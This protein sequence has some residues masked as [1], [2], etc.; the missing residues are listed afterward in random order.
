M[1]KTFTHLIISLF[2]LTEMC[3][4]V[5]AQNYRTVYENNTSHFED[6]S[7]WTGLRTIYRTIH[8]DSV[9][10]TFGG[11]ELFNVMSMQDSAQNM[12]YPA[13]RMTWI[14]AKIVQTISGDEIY[15]TSTDDTVY[16]LPQSVLNGSWHMY[17]Y[18]N[19]NYI[20]AKVVDV[21]IQNFIGLND[22][23]KT[24]QLTAKDAGGNP[25]SNLLNGRLLKLSENHGWVQTLGFRYFPVDTTLFTLVGLENEIAGIQNLT[26][27]QIFDFDIGDEFHTDDY[28]QMWAA[29]WLRWREIRKILSKSFSVDSDTVFYSVD[30]CFSYEHQYFSNYTNN[31]GHD[32]IIETYALPVPSDLH[33]F[34]YQMRDTS[35]AGWQ[36]LNNGFLTFYHDASYNGRLKKETHYYMADNLSGCWET[37]LCDPPPPDVQYAE[38]LGWIGESSYC[39]N[40]SLV[41]YRKGLQQW[42]TPLNCS[43][44]LSN[45][46]ISEQYASFSVYPNPVPSNS[47]SNFTFT[48]SPLNHPA[49][50]II[51]NIDGREVMRY[52]VLPGSVS[53]KIKLPEL[54][55]GVYVARLVGEGVNANVKFVV[56]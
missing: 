25:V 4:T 45:N 39:S 43:I 20:E 30:K 32:T 14:A 29:E 47:N 40:G 12:C 10:V 35:A 16:M 2:C 56:E 48:H 51:N 31:S 36:S 19:G 18:S 38:G 23:V 7:Y 49:D 11:T 54:T 27:R 37:C 33:Q 42:G 21:S 8:I 46:N 55:K 5:M 22:S 44:L 15:Y 50:I 34:S 52:H 6:S 9:A 24:I 17:T 26:P 53:E 1:N 13:N 3:Q 41:Y 28:F